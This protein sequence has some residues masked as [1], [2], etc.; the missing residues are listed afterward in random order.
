MVND[1]VG[2]EWRNHQYTFLWVVYSPF[3]ILA[4]YIRFKCQHFIQFTKPFI[5]V[6]VEIANLTT[7]T[8]S[9]LCIVLSQ[10]QIFVCVEQVVCV[11]YHLAWRT[12]QL[13][14]I[15]NVKSAILKVGVLIQI[16]I[17]VHLPICAVSLI[18]SFQL[19]TRTMLITIFLPRGKVSAA[20]VSYFS[21][22]TKR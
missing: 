18:Q 10:T 2:K 21:I 9:M 19:L 16:C 17:C 13:A 12:S 7:F 15:S 14:C 20:S 3:L 11:L 1:A 6:F 22:E 5:D 8:L 4:G